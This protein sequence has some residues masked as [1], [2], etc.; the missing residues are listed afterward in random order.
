[1]DGWHRIEQMG[2]DVCSGVDCSAS[3]RVVTFGMTDSS[4][5]PRV[6][7]GGHRLQAV[8]TFRGDS[9]HLESRTA[10]LDEPIHRCRIWVTQQLDGVGPFPRLSQERPLQVDA[11]DLVKVDE[12]TKS[13]NLRDDVVNCRSHRRSKQSRRSL[14]AV[15]MDG[16]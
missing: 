16:T 6:T 13:L 14:A 15:V 12:S 7:E 4:V 3:R 9:H 10:S 2:H 11:G 8:R 1:M 5:Y